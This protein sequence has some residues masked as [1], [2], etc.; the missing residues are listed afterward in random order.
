[1]NGLTEVLSLQSM[2]DVGEIIATAAL[3]R[4]ES[5]GMHFRRDFPVRNDSEW[6]KNIIVRMEDGIKRVTVTTPSY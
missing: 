3:T 2:V 6:L 1:M 4:E 5:R